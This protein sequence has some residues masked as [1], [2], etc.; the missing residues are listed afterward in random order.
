MSDIFGIYYCEFIQY[1]DTEFTS[2]KAPHTFLKKG[3]GKRISNKNAKKEPFPFL[4]KGC[5][6]LASDYHGETEFAKNRKEQVIREQLEREMGY[7]KKPID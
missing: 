5:G 3:E 1:M 4:K 7:G 2:N 6:K